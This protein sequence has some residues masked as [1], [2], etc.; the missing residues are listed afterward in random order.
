MCTYLLTINYMKEIF[1]QVSAFLSEKQVNF[2]DYG[3][4]KISEVAE[5]YSQE[6]SSFS[7]TLLKNMYWDKLLGVVKF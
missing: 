6:F 3:F 1:F 5:D 7:E 4:D 2:N